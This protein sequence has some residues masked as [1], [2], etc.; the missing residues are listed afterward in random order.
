MKKAEK[1]LGNT[2]TGD[3]WKK[4]SASMATVSKVFDGIKAG[5][6]GALNSLRKLKTGFSNM[7]SVIKKL[8]SS[9]GSLFS[10]LTGLA[11]KAASAVTGFIRS[12]TNAFSKLTGAGTGIKSASTGISGLIKAAGGLLAARGLVSFSKDAIE[13]GSD[14]T[15]V[16]NVVDTA[17]GSM[18]NKV[19]DFASTAAEQFGL[20]EYAAKQYSGTMM[21]MLKSSGVAQDAAADMSVTLAGLSG[22]LASFYNIDT[23]EAFRK[24]RAGISGETEPLKQLGINMNIVNLEAYAMSQGITKAYKDMTLAEQSILRYN[25]ILAKT[26]DAQ[27]DFARTA[28]TWANQLR[29]LR[30]NIQSISAIIG[31]GLIAALLPAI[32]LLNKFMAKLTEAAKKFRDFMYVLFGKKIESPTRGIV[33]DMAGSVDYTEDLSG[34]SDSAEDIEDDMEDAADGTDDLTSSMKKL[35]KQLAVLNFDELNQLPKQLDAITDSTSKKDK[36]KKDD[37]GLDDLGL[38]NM[39]DLF[40]ELGDKD[41]IEPVNEWARRLREAFLNHD[42]EELGKILAEMVNIGLKKLYD[43]IKDITPKVESALRALARVINSFVNWLDWDLLGRT[44]GAGINL[45]ARSFNALFGP[46]GIDL[47]NLGRKLSVGLRG[48]IDEVDWRGLGN[49]IGN[50]FMIAWRIASGFVEDMWRINPDTLTTG[51]AEVGNALAEAVHGIFERINFPQIG[52]TLSDGFNG[53]VEII[54]NFRNTMADNR[55]WSMIGQGISEGLNNVMDGIDLSGMAEQLSGLAL[56][57]LYMLNDA[58]E[59][60]HWSDFGY[61]IAEALFSIPWLDLFNQVFDFIMATFGEATLGFIDYLTTNAEQLG[62]SFATWVNTIFDKVKYL[63]DN[64]PWDDISLGLTNWLNSAIANIDWETNGQ[65]LNEFVT[66]LLG[67]FHDVAENTNWE[68][69][70][71][72]IG[73]FL[74]QIDWAT[75]LGTVFDT[76]WEILSGLLAGLFDTEDGKIALTIGGGILAIKGLFD[77]ADFALT[78]AQ[79]ATGGTDKFTLLAEGAQMLFSNLGNI[80]GLIGGLFSPTGLMVAGIVAGA[81]WII[82]HWDEVKGTFEYLWENVLV[83]LGEFVS[84]VFTAVW[85]DVLSPALQYLGE[86]VLPV[87]SDTLSN[88]WKNVIDPLAK[89]ISDVV[90]PI[91]E[92]LTEVFE[93]LWKNVLKPL[94]DFLGTV[95]AGAFEIVMA[96]LNNVVIPIVSAVIAIF[97]FLWEKVLSPVATFVMDTLAPVFTT[98][99]QAIG[100]KIES[101]RQMFK[102]LI[103]FV[104]GVFTGDWSRAWEGVKTIFGGIWDG[105]AGLVRAPVN[106]V[107]RFINGL[108]G[109]VESGVN[110]VAKMLNKLNVKAPSWVTKLTGIT[111]IGFNLPTWT[112][113]RIP[114][115]EKG[116][117]LKKGQTGYLEGN[118]AEAV[119]PLEKNTQWIKKVSAELSEKLYTGV[120]HSEVV[121][122]THE[123]ILTTAKDTKWISEQSER[124]MNNSFAHSGGID[125]DMLAAAVE[126]G[127]VYALMNNIQ[128]LQGKSPQYIQNSIY[129]DR[130]VLLRAVTEAQNEKDYRCNPTPAY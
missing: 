40:D 73:E 4:L 89:F 85:Q 2:N 24:L 124:M 129:L 108:I 84:T 30:L 122:A 48:M 16:E 68:E 71:R 78:V 55:T 92:K 100:D 35:E 15:E 103:D 1:G 31:Q 26:G 51:W 72:N 97:Q 8:S 125:E 38:G 50:Y 67:V 114:Y 64:I 3:G 61:K 80:T 11:S 74:G 99:F 117:V 121:Q 32:K 66:K 19:Y 98:A 12:M 34:I 14:I 123:G 25:Y 79:W 76:I 126:K 23:D 5:T 86:T 63:T 94:A 42:W 105:I 49:A 29:L 104:A 39:D 36:D 113:A 47:E 54:R 52:K 65:I 69:L 91:I 127:V 9:V 58:A 83:P 20:S 87:L 81:A 116:G 119:V 96:I 46:G 107:I 95:F 59:Q 17:F 41:V 118:G 37:L 57:L 45:L 102:G 44:I 120:L 75:H 13:L 88:L 70:G 62:V 27:G 56:D 18:A 21:A 53:I 60:T 90:K 115:L 33:D 109:G 77:A 111:S 130:D 7:L 112:A 128:N 110:S 22:D 101:A 28:G 82:T 106:A 93:I 6:S 10:K 43:F